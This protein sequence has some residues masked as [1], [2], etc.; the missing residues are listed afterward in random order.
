MNN[1]TDSDFSNN[2]FWPIVEISLDQIPSILNAAD[3][4]AFDE[5]GRTQLTYKGW[6][7]Y[8]FGQDTKEVIIKASAFHPQEFG[9]L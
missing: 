3:F 2:D 9:R 7:L 8:H 4:G 1:Y 5:F 6:P